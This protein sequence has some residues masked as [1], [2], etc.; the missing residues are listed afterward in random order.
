MN[1]DELGVP[2]MPPEPFAE[3]QRRQSRMDG[4]E[5]E[6]E[7]LREDVPVAPAMVQPHIERERAGASAEIRMPLIG[8]DAYRNL[9]LTGAFR[10]IFPWYRQRFSVGALDDALPPAVTGSEVSRPKYGQHKILF[11]RGE[12]GHVI[13]VLKFD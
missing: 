9:S 13:S 6:D 7:S 4:G 5:D 3:K 12:D 1:P 11:E 8:A 10:C 2:D